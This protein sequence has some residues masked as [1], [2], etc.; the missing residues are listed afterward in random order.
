MIGER[1]EL[2]HAFGSARGLDVEER[3]HI[4]SRL[5]VAKDTP[6]PCQT[7]TLALPLK[8]G[9]YAL[10]RVRASRPLSDPSYPPVL[11]VGAGAG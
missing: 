11:P 2:R 7:P 6:S 5:T 1:A 8:G 3:E 10:T 9:G 4:V